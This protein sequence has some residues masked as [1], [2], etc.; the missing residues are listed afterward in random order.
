MQPDERIRWQ[1]MI[2]AAED[3]MDFMAGRKRADLDQERRSS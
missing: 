1:H 2:D 3:A